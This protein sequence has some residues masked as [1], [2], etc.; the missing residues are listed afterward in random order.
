M[1][2]A[3]D[4]EKEDAEEG[5]EV[6]DSFAQRIVASS[7]IRV[8]NDPDPPPPDRNDDEDCCMFLM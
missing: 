2:D 5:D 6:W 3:T 7:F 4:E 8:D 1:A